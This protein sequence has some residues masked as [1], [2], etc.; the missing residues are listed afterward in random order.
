MAITDSDSG[1][2]LLSVVVVVL[3][4]PTIPSTHSLFQ[5]F[6]FENA[7]TNGCYSLCMVDMT[8]GRLFF[9]AFYAIIII[10]IGY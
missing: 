1:C 10:I 3:G 8:G 7:V 9:F 2:C 6:N 5:V 4:P